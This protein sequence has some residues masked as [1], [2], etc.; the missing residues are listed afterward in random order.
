[1]QSVGTWK[2]LSFNRKL[3]KE[4]KHSKP[5]TALLRKTKT[6][7]GPYWL[8]TR[9]SNVSTLKVGF[10]S[11]LFTALGVNGPEASIR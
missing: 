7:R 1:M 11:I 10:K 3:S 8:N 6:F 9:I 4:V 2:G 5:T